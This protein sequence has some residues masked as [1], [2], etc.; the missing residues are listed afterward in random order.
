SSTSPAAA[1]ATRNGAQD[2]AEYR[3]HNYDEDGNQY[4]GEIA[5]VRGFRLRC[6]GLH[7]GEGDVSIFS[8]DLCHTLRYQPQG[9]AIFALPEKRDC[10][11]AKAADFAIG[12]DWLQPVANLGAIAMVIHRQQNQH[13]AIDRL[14]PDAPL[15]VK[16]GGVAFNVG[17]I[18]RADSDHGN[19]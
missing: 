13:T 18:E 4:P 2:G 17:T 6:G 10:F 11:A 1:S 19:L 15:L 12:Q 16:I 3:N 8:D 9:R 14:G 7:A 5:V